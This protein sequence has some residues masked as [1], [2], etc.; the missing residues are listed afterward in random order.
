MGAADSEHTVVN[1]LVRVMKINAMIR[2]WENMN[3]VVL[4]ARE[5]ESI[6]E[7][8]RILHVDIVICYTVHHKKAHVTLESGHICDGRVQVAFRIV[9]GRVHVALGVN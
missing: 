1:H 7:G 8:E 9:L 3:I 6:Q 2:I 4:D 5:V